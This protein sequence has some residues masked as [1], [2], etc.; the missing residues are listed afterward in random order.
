MKYLNCCLIILASIISIFWVCVI[1]NLHYFN[2][3][4]KGT[5]TINN[6]TY[7]KEENNMVVNL[8]TSNKY[9]YELEFRGKNTTKNTIYYN[10]Y[11]YDNK[12]EIFLNIDELETEVYGFLSDVKNDLYCLPNKIIKNEYFLT[13]INLYDRILIME[14]Y[15]SG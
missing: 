14:S 11:A 9:L 8:K 6:I 2:N 12:K 5:E 1:D 10:V 15:S 4:F 3:S 7:Q 13:K